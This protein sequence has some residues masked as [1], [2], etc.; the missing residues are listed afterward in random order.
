MDRRTFE[1]FYNGTIRILAN[2]ICE[3]NK[4]LVFIENLGGLYEEYLNQ[5]T[6]LKLLVK[7]EENT[8]ET[9]LIDRHK[10]SACM[11]VAIMKTRLLWYDGTDEINGNYTLRDASRMNEQLSFLCGLN[12]LTFYMAIEPGVKSTLND[13]LFPPTYQRGETENLNNSYLD[14]II[15]ALFY[16][17]ITS[18]PPALLLSNIFFLLEEYHKLAYSV[19]KTG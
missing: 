17:N 5:K 18:G 15:R 16:S 9:N 11:T 7:N 1:E 10:I 3:K 12:V 4:N 6:L 19:K 2:G 8:S 13:F 14:S